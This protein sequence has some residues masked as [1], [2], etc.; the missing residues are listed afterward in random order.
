M[1]EIIASSIEVLRLPS[2][3]LDDRK[4]LPKLPGVYFAIGPDGVVQYIGQA[5]SVHSRWNKSGGHHQLRNLQEIGGVRIGYLCGQAIDRKKLE[6]DL[7][8]HFQPVL[9]RNPR[10]KASGGKRATTDARARANAKW[11]REN[12]GQAT[13]TLRKSLIKQIEDAADREGI[14]RDRWLKST[15]KKALEQIDE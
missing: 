8:A 3:P 4:D 13:L 11:N 6:A 5:A 9:N 7:I 1:S 12:M 15:I 2:I 14:T 10:S